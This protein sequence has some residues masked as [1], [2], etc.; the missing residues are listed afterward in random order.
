MKTLV[1]EGL[2]WGDEGK[3]KITDYL[4]INSDVVVRF[5]GGNNA[6][7]TINFDGNKYA[8]SL[9]PSGVFSGS[10]TN[11]LANGMVI[12]PEALIKE[13]DYMHN[14]GFEFNL[15]ISNRAHVTLPYHMDLDGAYESLK[16]GKLIGTTKK[17]IGP[18]YS[19]KINRIG[20]R[21][22]DLL[23]PTY[24]KETLADTLKIKNRELELFDLKQYTVD[25]LF[26][27]CMY[28]KEKLG[29]LIADTSIIIN[30]AIAA[31]KKVLFEGAQGAM[32]CLDNGTYPYVTSSSPL[33]ASVPLNAGIAPRYVTEVLGIIK[34]YNTR[35]GE[36]PFPTEIDGPLGEDIRERGHE[37]GTVTGRSRRIGYFDGVVLKH[38]IRL[39]GVTKLSLMLFDVLSSVKELKVCYAYELDG[40]EIDYIPANLE[41]F[42]RCKPLYKVLE[43][44]DEDITAVKLYDELPV[45]AKKYI[46]CLEEIGGVP[47]NLVSVGPDRTQ[48][49][50]KKDLEW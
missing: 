39:S 6:G 29:H 22:G 31:D 49:I 35:V 26:D 5:Q 24:L 9:L 13:M 2:Q 28:Y 27:R 12:N 15:V 47:I 11:V 37:Y 7:H 44:F 21:M 34:A 33:A 42:A 20:I 50:V 18:T 36:G 23:N 38:A 17:G 8:L 3:G 48:T 1:V 19:D 46:N 4:A 25:E 14:N 10:T 45:N 40:K 16:G 41:E 32:L 43:G 30:D